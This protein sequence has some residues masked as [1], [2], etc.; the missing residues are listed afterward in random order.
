M[1][2]LSLKTNIN[3]GISARLGRLFSHI[4]LSILC[5]LRAIAL[6]QISQ[7]QEK[8]KDWLLWEVYTTSE[9]ISERVEHIETFLKTNTDR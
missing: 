1:H 2:T 8:K 7:Q 3:T 5:G 4:R 9:Y 6:G